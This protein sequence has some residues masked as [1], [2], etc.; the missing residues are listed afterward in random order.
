[1]EYDILN[2]ILTDTVGSIF[3][4]ELVYGSQGRTPLK[5]YTPKL[6]FDSKIK[7]KNRIFILIKYIFSNTFLRRRKKIWFKRHKKIKLKCISSIR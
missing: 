2:S 4:E 3:E 5:I 7:T 1:M 6:V